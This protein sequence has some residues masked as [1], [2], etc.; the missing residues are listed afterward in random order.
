MTEEE[1]LTCTDPQ[2]M[3][4]FLRGSMS[5]RKT[6]LFSAACCRRVWALLHDHR[7]RRA[8][9]VV[10]RYADGKAT[11]EELHNASVDATAAVDQVDDIR[12]AADALAFYAVMVASHVTCDPAVVALD[13]VLEPATQADLLR[14]IIGSPFK[15]YPAPAIWPSTVVELAASLYEGHDCRL[16]LS[17]A[18]EESG[19]GEVAEHF[20]VEEWHPKGCWVLDLILNKQ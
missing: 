3:L 20:R 12:D 10:E 15:P 16:P 6:R 2:P 8:V 17:D 18:L 9:E 4:E 19:H 5:D 13:V 11:Q 14:H 7:S 1:W